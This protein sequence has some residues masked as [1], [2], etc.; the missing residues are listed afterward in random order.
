MLVFRK[1][2][3]SKISRSLG[4]S[5]GYNMVLGKRNSK[6]SLS[7][8][9]PGKLSRWESVCRVHCCAVNSN[10]EKGSF[11]CN[12]LPYLTCVDHD[13]NLINGE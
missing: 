3:H 5:S 2:V 9:A 10:S 13:R 7:T 8:R 11:L 6:M 1:S 4:I 12:T